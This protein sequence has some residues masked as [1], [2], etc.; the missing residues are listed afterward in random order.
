VSDF[1]SNRGL[2]TVA[3][4]FWQVF[5]YVQQFLNIK[6]HDLNKVTLISAKSAQY[7]LPM[8]LQKH[9]LCYAFSTLHSIFSLLLPFNAAI[10]HHN[11]TL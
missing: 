10:R 7:M 11:I 6:L 3:C 8:S 2:D 1:P 4:Q 5:I 9:C